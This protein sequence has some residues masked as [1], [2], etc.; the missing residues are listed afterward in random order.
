[1]EDGTSTTQAQTVLADNLGHHGASMGQSST[2][3][4][5]IYYDLDIPLYLKLNIKNYLICLLGYLKFG[6]EDL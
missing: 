4:T 3:T 1:M 6:A 5:E 2:D